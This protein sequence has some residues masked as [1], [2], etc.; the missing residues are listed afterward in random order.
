[1]IAEICAES[2]RQIEVMY[3]G[4]DR[5]FG[6]DATDSLIEPEMAPATK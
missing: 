5:H 6:V 3:G 2:D 1:M 4:L